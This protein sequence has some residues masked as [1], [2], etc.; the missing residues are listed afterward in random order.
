L[1]SYDISSA[2]PWRLAAYGL[3]AALALAEAA[4]LW[5]ALHPEVHPDYRAFYIDRS[6]TCLNKEVAGTYR[7]GETV[8]FRPDG[9]KQAAPLKVCGWTGA[10]GNGTHSRGHTS[11]LR[12]ALADPPPPDGFTATVELAPVTRPGSGHREVLI[13]VN[14]VQVHRVTLPTP[15][16]REV[17]FHIPPFAVE[18]SDRLDIRFD[19]PNPLS[20]G[21]MASNTFDRA[22]RLSSLRIE[23][24]R[25]DKMAGGEEL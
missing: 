18:G 15:E 21:P 14:A 13:S 24:G 23:P 2:A 12:I 10:A 9:A 7:L 25:E 4:I 5:L 6:T 11:L 3:V 19:Y 20:T 1:R 17:V 22:M 8:S 16:P